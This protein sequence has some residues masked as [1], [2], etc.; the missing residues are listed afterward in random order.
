MQAARVV[1]WLAGCA[2]AFAIVDLELADVL[3]GFGSFLGRV[4]RA[5]LEKGFFGWME[6]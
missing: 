4:I 6:P 3:A 5:L 1:Y 2:P